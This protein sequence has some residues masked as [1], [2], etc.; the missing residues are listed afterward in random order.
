MMAI[1]PFA[2]AHNRLVAGSNPPPDH[3]LALRVKSNRRARSSRAEQ[4]AH[5]RLVAGSN[6]AGPTTCNL[7]RHLP[8]ISKDFQP[9]INKAEL[10]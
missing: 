9:F 2:T 1:A 10:P 8:L 5:N 7:I 3:E 4:A 6:P